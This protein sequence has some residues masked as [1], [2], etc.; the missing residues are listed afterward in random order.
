MK[1]EERKEKEKFNLQS[2]EARNVEYNGAQNRIFCTCEMKRAEWKCY[3][4]I[5]RHKMHYLY[6]TYTNIQQKV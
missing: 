4:S 2:N 3:S 1:G 6:N 5:E